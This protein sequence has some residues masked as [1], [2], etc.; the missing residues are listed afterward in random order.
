[1]AKQTSVPSNHLYQSQWW[2]RLAAISEKRDIEVSA[3]TQPVQKEQ[4][5]FSKALAS[6]FPPDQ[7][8]E[9]I[10]IFVKTN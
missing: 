8:S 10:S 6:L 5:N 4:S 7:G 3:N 9:L 2:A 1:M